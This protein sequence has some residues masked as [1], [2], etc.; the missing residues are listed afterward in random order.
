MASVS[1]EFQGVQ[2]ASLP[3]TL[4]AVIGLLLVAWGVVQLVRRRTR[5]GLVCLA[6]AL[7]PAA[8]VPAM[9]ADA[10]LRYARG[11]RREG[12]AS[13][14]AASAAA[15]GAAVGGLLIVNQAR[16][17]WMV[18]LALQI[19]IAVG[20]FYSTAYAYLGRGRILALM[21]LRCAG[22]LALLLVL[23]KPAL[24][25]SPGSAGDRPCLPILVD[26]SASMATADE[27]NLPDRYHQAVEALRVQQARLEKHFRPLW[28]QFATAVRRA[29]S[30]GQLAEMNAAGEGAGGTDLAAAI[31]AAA[32]DRPRADLAGIVVLTD[33]IHNGAEAVGDAAV[34]AGVPVYLV[35]VGSPDEK[36]SARRNVQIVSVDAPMEAVVNNVTAI[37]VRSKLAGFPAAPM[38]LQLLEEGAEGKPADTQRLWTDQNVATLAAQLKWTPGEPISGAATQSTRKSADAVRRLKVRIPPNPAETVAEDNDFEL[39]VL[40]TQ[41]HIRVL[42]VEGTIRPEYKFLSRLLKSDPNIRF[43]ALVRMEGNR[44]WSQGDIAGRKLDKLPETEA[45]FALFDVIILGDLDR[46]FLSKEQMALLR[47]FVNGGGGLLML[48]GHSSFGP[49]GYGGTDVEAVLPVHC[50]TRNQGQER[51]PFVP[52]LTA[53][54]EMHPI[55]EGL[56]GYFLGPAG[57]RPDES[58]QKLPSLTGCV[59][60]AGL[61]S[62][63]L[64]LAI[65]PARP[66]AIT[67]AVQN[68][69]AGRSA[70]FTADTTW[71]WYLSLHGLGAD[72][73]YERFW[74]QMVR[75]LANV[76]TKA[77]ESRPS[78]VLRLDRTYVRAGDDPV[79]ILCR[80]QD[81]KGRPAD[82]AQVSVEIAPAAGGAKGDALPLSP[83]M[84]DR[85]FEGE[86]RPSKEGTYR[87][88]A[89]ARD[90]AGAAL[91]SDELTLTVAAYS[92]ETDRLARNDALMQL[93]A[94]RSAGRAVDLAAL[95]DLIDQIARRAKSRAGAPGGRE[96]RIVTLHNFTF[97][98]LAFVTLLTAEWL[99]RRQWH[100]R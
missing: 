27:T 35:G 76:T 18:A 29:E 61:K 7:G 36:V 66:E 41:P 87:V 70:A 28:Y 40:L 60:V 9:V 45:E 64:N 48:G 55:F 32:E 20:V 88:T 39:H 86:H 96:G 49:G 33:G 57:R 78:V 16:A 65:H 97:L 17:V 26:R 2:D 100:L 71:N 89:T 10:A 42:Y 77:R 31:R 4:V 44:F 14:L 38:E 68:V 1:L 8:F 93:V 85:L 52:Q 91:G 95:P 75:W 21:A 5:H 59:T 80:V 47:K 56:K 98:F 13:L 34:E 94:D 83:R 92:T 23:F 25:I 51:A 37:T 67:L 3:L 73:P 24:N 6:A 84:G 22:I 79:K 82:N 58:L 72:S 50:G 69:G 90:A 54:G 12:G 53:I 15:G 99:L 63:A 43:V 11:N 81:D 30:P 19:A 62:G 46:T 74:G